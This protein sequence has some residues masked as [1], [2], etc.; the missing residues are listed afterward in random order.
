MTHTAHHAPRSTFRVSRLWFFML[1]CVLLLT[2]GSPLPLHADGPLPLSAY[3]RPADD[4][5]MGIHWSTNL[6]G[7]SHE[8]TDYFVRE[9]VSMGIKW[10]K[11]LNDGTEGRQ[12]DYLVR[13]LVAHDIMPV[14]RIYSRNN[15]PL[16]ISSLRRLV[17]HY[18]PMGVYY[19][20]L[21]NE[22]N[23]PGVDGGWV[24][25][26]RRNVDDLLRSWV[27]AAR[28][29]EEEGGYPSV[30]SMF[31]PSTTDPKF[32][33]SFFQQFFRR[34]KANGDTDVLY[35]AWIALHNYTINHPIRYPY[36]NANLHG[37]P[38][39]AA[40]IA[41]YGLSANEVQRINHFRAIAHKPRSEGGYYVG[42]TIYEDNYGFLQFLAYHKQFYDIFG[43]EIPIIGTEG[44]T[45]VG[46]GD[47]P[48]YP[49]ITPE[50]QRDMTLEAYNYMLDEAPPYF[51]AYTSWLLAQKALDYP[52][53]AWETDAWYHDRKGNHLPVV[54]ALKQFSRRGETRRNAPGGNR[55]RTS[56]GARNVARASATADTSAY[57]NLA[58]FPRPP[59]D[60][61]WG[62]HW[63]TGLFGQPPSVVDRYI[64]ELES[65]NIRW[66]KIVQGDT[67]KVAHPYLIRR[68]VAAGIMP[69]VR[70]YQEYNEPPRH[71]ASL[72]RS[73]RPMGVYY[74]ELFNEPNIA[75][76]PGGWRPGE[77]IDVDR[78][79]SL[80]I[81]AAETVIREGGFPSL[82]ALT[83]GGD[84]DDVAFLDAFLT[85]VLR[86]GRKDLLRQ[87]WLPLHNY[88]LNHPLNYPEDP[89]NLRSVP[90]SAAEAARRG[91][92]ATQVQAINH[93][94]Q[95]AHLP[96]S[97]GGYFRGR[98]IYQD[99]NAFRK[100]EAYHKVVME[101]VGFAMPIISTEG[102]AIAGSQEDPRYPPVT[103]D[104]VARWTVAAYNYMLDQAP[105]YYFAFTPWLLVNQAAG[106]G[107]SWE[108]AA[109]YKMDGT[110]LPVVSA[111]KQ[112]VRG[113]RTRERRYTP[114]TLRAWAAAGAPGNA[115]TTSGSAT[116]AIAQPPAQV[117]SSPGPVS[118]GREP[119]ALYATQA[120][121][122]RWQ[123]EK[124]GLVV[125]S[126]IANRRVV[127]RLTLW[128]NGGSLVTWPV[129]LEAGG[130]MTKKWRLVDAESAIGLQLVDSGGRTLAKYGVTSGATPRALSPPTRS[131]PYTATPRQRSLQ[132]DTRLDGL[133]VRLVKAKARRGD[134]L[135]RLVRAVYQDP[136]ESSGNHNIYVE[137]LDEKGRRVLGHRVWVVWRGGQAPLITQDK[138]APEYAANFPMY[139]K[140]GSYRV[141]VEGVSDAV[142]G[143]GLPVRHHV[144]FLLTFQRTRY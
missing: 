144:N 60:N 99:S 91:L 5:G 103:D 95:I 52:N 139:G 9:L 8:T 47:D 76:R 88:F 68:L 119:Y 107:S 24:G 32:E 93:A 77:S 102:G 126:V 56:L 27:P 143:M 66:V 129:D 114:A 44:G 30:P 48:R 17:R 6:Y 2:A 132:W 134:S 83:P 128:A 131:K 110:T 63:S 13:Q 57:T 89:V 69:I 4:N 70:V 130:D 138:P 22:P 96:R 18:R 71:L 37:T 111:L 28:A 64:T 31:P 1:G 41:R 33:R 39:T 23:F 35:R 97:Q 141:E 85:A 90:L 58:R 108:T 121:T 61:G 122:L 120:A 62:V 72:V 36:D 67:P 87:S 29:I 125:I 45:T 34:L 7:E 94:R 98:T 123:R 59:Q 74:Y 82:P 117:T 118:P 78:L 40:E 53:T 46:N 142:T 51:F 92:S 112:N 105:P 73:G 75:G 109:W 38:L 11:F 3:P 43:F 116:P 16:D 49:R 25:D 20:E 42:S 15:N 115:P 50:M 137:L 26:K 21:F 55:G 86:R 81:P 113:K 133:G 84:Y 135:W 14:M 127:G 10:V 106:G 19:Y 124:T 65:L 12:H 140:I 104:D 79:V 80:W 100:F 136:T 54:E 101:R